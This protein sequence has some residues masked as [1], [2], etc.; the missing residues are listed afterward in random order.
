MDISVC[1]YIYGVDVQEHVPI[2]GLGS[3][4]EFKGWAR[5]DI[6]KFKITQPGGKP[7]YKRNHMLEK[8]LNSLKW[9]VLPL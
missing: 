3:S 4:C 8:D 9:E 5:W 7:G 1:V 6:K 2:P